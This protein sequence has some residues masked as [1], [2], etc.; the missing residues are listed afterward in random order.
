MKNKMIYGFLSLCILQITYLGAMTGVLSDQ[1]K[2][3]KAIQTFDVELLKKVNVKETNI[4]KVSDDPFQLTPLQRV[5]SQEEPFDKKQQVFV[6]MLIDRSEPATVSG[7]GATALHYAARNG[8]KGAVKKL[9]LK[10]QLDPFAF[11]KRKRTPI[12]ETAYRGHSEIVKLF[13][14]KGKQLQPVKN[15]EGNTVLHI[16]AQR[17][18]F[19]DPKIVKFLVRNAG[20]N[21]RA[22]NKAEDT[23]LHIIVEQD[24]DADPT[25]VNAFLNEIKKEQ[26]KEVLEITDDQGRTVLHR[27]ISF[28]IK[29]NITELLL[30]E[31]VDPNRRDNRGRTVFHNL[32]EAMSKYEAEISALAEAMSQYET[33]IP[34]T[35]DKKEQLAPFERVAR[36]LLKE[37]ADPL[38]ADNEGKTPLDLAQGEYT[39]AFIT[40]ILKG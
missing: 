11:D 30:K 12:E 16:V 2:L 25:F 31:K 23:P 17:S 33:E 35:V 40:E 18:L 14:P 22:K 32:A 36:L 13:L 37:K 19:H 39:K 10:K 34:V 28:N 3:D 27:A 20:A 8:H 1:E 15:K 29:P 26:R 5:L 4:N 38:A 9:F 21:I 24:K 6:E 7:S